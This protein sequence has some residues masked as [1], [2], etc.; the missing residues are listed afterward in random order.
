M[1]RHRHA[2]QAHV[3]QVI[4]K[5]PPAGRAAQETLNGAQLF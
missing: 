5:G 1:E 3:G 2:G 4:V